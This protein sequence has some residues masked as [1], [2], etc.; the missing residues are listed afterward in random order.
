MHQ[1]TELVSPDISDSDG[2]VVFYHSSKFLKT[3][4]KLVK[5][6]LNILDL[7]AKLHAK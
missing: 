5:K 3:L 2:K 1:S 4:F 7:Y 6:D